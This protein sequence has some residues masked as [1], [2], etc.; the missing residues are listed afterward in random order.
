MQKPW[1]TEI[2][3]T[4]R[5]QNE[6]RTWKHIAWWNAGE[7]RKNLFAIKKKFKWKMESGIY[8]PFIAESTI[9]RN[10]PENRKKNGRK[11][12]KAGQRDKKPK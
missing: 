11:I 6:N 10:L 3:P 2:H 7:G 5:E 4:Q 8:R 12:E 9:R 1:S